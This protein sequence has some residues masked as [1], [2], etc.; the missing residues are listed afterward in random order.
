MKAPGERT[1]TLRLHVPWDAES[2][3]RLYEAC[4]ITAW[5][6][7]AT[8]GFEADVDNLRL[9]GDVTSGLLG[10]GTGELTLRQAGQAPIETGLGMRM[11]R[12]AQRDVARW[13]RCKRRG[14]EAQVRR[15]VGADR[16]RRDDRVEGRHRRREPL[17]AR[18]CRRSHL[19]DRDGGG[20]S[21]RARKSGFATTAAMPRRA[22]A[23]RSALSCATRPV[24]WSSKGRFAPCSPMKNRATRSG[25]HRAP[26]GSPQARRGAGS[27]S[28][29]RRDGE[30]QRTPTGDCGRQP[31]RTGS[32]RDGD[33][34]PGSGLDAELG[35]R[36]RKPG[37]RN[38]HRQRC[39]PLRRNTIDTL[40][41]R[42]PDR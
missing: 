41:L 2:S 40:R 5:G 30:A 23:S 17:A 6:R 12:S 37:R 19:R 3:Q 18:A 15:D 36:G 7:V 27:R 16:V 8:E 31:M 34:E 4:R 9:D 26:S 38:S 32:L 33:F 11:G 24:R 22:P 28:P 1:V 42:C 29:W 25:A 20:H 13:V 39:G 14:G 10:F 35:Y 21:P